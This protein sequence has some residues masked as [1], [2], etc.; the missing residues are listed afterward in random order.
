MNDTN[1]ASTLLNEQ[2][3]Q[4][5]LNSQVLGLIKSAKSIQDL[6]KIK[7]ELIGVN[8][9][10]TNELKK[11]SSLTIEEKKASGSKLNKLKITISSLIKEKEDSLSSFNA[12]LPDMSLLLNNNIGLQ[13]IISE[14]IDLLHQIFR[15]IGFSFFEGPDIEKAYYNFDALN[16]PEHHPARD[17]NDTFYM[18]SDKSELLRTQVT[19]VQIRLLESLKDIDTDI[20][21]YSIGNVFRND[22]HDPTHSCQFQQIEGIILEKDV[23]MQHLKGFVEYLLENFFER[24]VKVVFRP[25]FFPFTE[26]SCEI[27]AYTKIIDGKLVLSEDGE[28]LEIG[29]C[30]IIHPSILKNFNKDGHQAFAFGM[31]LERWIMLK[32]GIK[33]IHSLYNNQMNELKF[34]KNTK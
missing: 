15:N 11:L 13:H 34:I 21:A 4:D 23:T 7:A 27:F 32:Y 28:P 24:K 5:S 14:S 29:G 30:G 10:I 22:D 6:H 12:S 1:D 31:G 9:F 33:N 25:S 17:N 20:R 8:G 3:E 19:A 16:M 18:N 2:T 26:P